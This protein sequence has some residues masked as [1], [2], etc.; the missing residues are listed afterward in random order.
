MYL[1]QDIIGI[2][3]LSWNVKFN[4]VFSEA[5]FCVDYMASL[6]LRRQDNLKYSLFPQMALLFLFH[7]VLVVVSLFCFCCS[8]MSPLVSYNTLFSLSYIIFWSILN[9]SIFQLFFS[10]YDF[11]FFLSW[12]PVDSM[13]YFNGVFIDHHVELQSDGFGHLYYFV[14]VVV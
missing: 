6:S 12:S 13:M 9:P 7:I 11:S 3:L 1:V 8:V 10:S 2:S 5:N 14:N 4:H